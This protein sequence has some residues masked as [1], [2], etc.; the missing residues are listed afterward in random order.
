[1]KAFIS[2]SSKQIAIAQRL[3]DFLESIE[4][5][6]FVANYD[7]RAASSWKDAIVE[8]LMDC[9][10]FIPLLSKFFRESDWCSQEMGIAF[11]QDKKF[12]PV[13]L[14]DTKPYGFLNHIQTG[15]TIYD[16]TPELVVCEGLM[17]LF[18]NTQGFIGLL[19]RPLGFRLSEAIFE[20][21]QPYF[22]KFNNVEI[23]E[24]IETS[25]SNYQIWGASKCASEYIPKLLAS[26]K[27][28][29]D[30]M[31][32]KKIMYQI[33]TGKRYPNGNAQ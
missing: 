33:E 24:I 22:S 27:S 20:R 23:N 16:V 32:F 8:N 7:L 25:I 5:D 18:K 1:M 6:S 31:L 12:I 30:S 13:S 17:E 2:Y 29:I 3:K 9:E 14:D 4:I 26:R 15:F 11:V 21:M 10:L 19:K 28:D